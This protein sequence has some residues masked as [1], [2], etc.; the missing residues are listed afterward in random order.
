MMHTHTHT[1]TK[2]GLLGTRIESHFHLVK[3]SKMQLFT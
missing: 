3:N 2:L 1:H